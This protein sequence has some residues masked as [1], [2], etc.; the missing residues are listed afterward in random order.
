NLSFIEDPTRIFRAVRYENRYDFRMDEQTK[1][2]ARACVDMHLV[3]DLSSV[4]L[5]EELIPLF[6]EPS[7]GWTLK[8]LF[9]LGVAREVHPKLAT[10]EK[11]VALVARLDALVAELGVEQEVIPWRLRLAAITRNMD[12]DELYMWLEKLKLKRADGDVVRAAVVMSPLLSAQLSDETMTDWQVYKLLRKIP[13]EAVVLAMA[14]TEAGPGESRMRRYLSDIRHRTLSVSGDD[15]L[16]FG[17]KKGPAVGR[18]LERLKE[19]RVEG[20]VQGRDA[21]LAAARAMLEGGR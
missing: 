10:G 4:R 19:M 16:A 9:E 7:V 17:L 18:I 13:L 15:I 21:E 2:L 14:R 8:R 1:A 3:G 20:T 11:T 12:H 5:R 6:S